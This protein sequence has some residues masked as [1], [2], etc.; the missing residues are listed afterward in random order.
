MS[1]EK[2]KKDNIPDR[3]FQA[4]KQEIVNGAFRPGDKLPPESTLSTELGVSKSSVKIA[5]QRLVTLGLVETKAGDGSY[6]RAFIPDE[7][8]SQMGEFL[9]SDS[10]ISHITEYRLVTELATVGV[11]MERATPENFASMERIVDQMDKAMASGDFHLHAKLDYEFHREICRATQNEIFLL[12]DGIIGKMLRQHTSI[13]NRAYLEKARLKPVP[14]EDVHRRLLK[15]IQ[16]KD[17][18]ACRQCYV[19]MFAVFE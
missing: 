10:D 13:L 18:E 4:L 2:I 16:R 7:Y 15:A 19:E 6:V 12:S 9:L 11:A 17:M 8:I 1:F 5:I 3:V 14:E